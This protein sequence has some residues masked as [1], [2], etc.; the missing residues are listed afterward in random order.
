M[1]TVLRQAANQ[2]GPKKDM[3][4]VV[5]CGKE[6]AFRSAARALG[7]QNVKAHYEPFPYA[8]RVEGP[9]LYPKAL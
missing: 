4:A 8:V 3:A 5:Y 2:A 9:S 1:A 7:L 6:K